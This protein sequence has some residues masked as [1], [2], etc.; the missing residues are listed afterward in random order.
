MS[1]WA[2]TAFDPDDTVSPLPP[3]PGAAAG[4]GR[5][6]RGAEGRGRQLNHGFHRRCLDTGQ[7]AEDVL[8]GSTLERS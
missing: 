3:V 5:P 1:G 6:Q 8:D 4:H 2:T 7:P